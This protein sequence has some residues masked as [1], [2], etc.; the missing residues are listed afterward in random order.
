M[1]KYLLQDVKLWLL[2]VICKLLPKICRIVKCI[3]VDLEG[4]NLYEKRTIYFVCYI[5]VAVQID[6]SQREY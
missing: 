4:V 2:I 1:V 3:H 5:T 6:A